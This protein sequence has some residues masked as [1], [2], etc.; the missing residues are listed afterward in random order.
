LLGSARRLRAWTNDAS[1]FDAALEALVAV[2][3]RTELDAS[4]RAYDEH[5]MD[6]TD[7]WGDLESFRTAA[8]SS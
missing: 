8:G 7:E 6:E 1:L 4:Y 2:H 5:P 3:R